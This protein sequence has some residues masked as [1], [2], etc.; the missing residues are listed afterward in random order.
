MNVVK[1]ERELKALD[2][3]ERRVRAQVNP[4]QVLLREIEKRRAELMGPVD[5][6]Q[7]KK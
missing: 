3:L 7:Q 5:V 2:S 1:L 6:G 4:S